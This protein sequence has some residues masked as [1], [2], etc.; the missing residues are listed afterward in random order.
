MADLAAGDPHADCVAVMGGPG[1]SRPA[2]TTSAL[3]AADHLA[4]L[5]GAVSLSDDPFADTVRAADRHGLL[6]FD[7]RDRVHERG[8]IDL[9]HWLPPRRPSSIATFATI[10]LRRVLALPPDATGQAT[11]ASVR[12]V[13]PEMGRTRGDAGGA[14]PAGIA[15]VECFPMIPG[16][17]SVVW[18]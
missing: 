11:R 7:D 4:H 8:L 14:R 3:H 6:A 5:R 17:W 10:G 18:G 13:C 9:L 16:Y 12:W 2:T 1:T 15:D